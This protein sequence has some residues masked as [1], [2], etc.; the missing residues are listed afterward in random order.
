MEKY[1]NNHSLHWTKVKYT[2]AKFV[3]NKNQ[4]TETLLFTRIT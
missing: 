1:V 3:V 4:R 2:R